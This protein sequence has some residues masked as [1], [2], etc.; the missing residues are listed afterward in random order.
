MA[1][2][3]ARP[4]AMTQPRAF[5]EQLYRTAVAAAHPASCL[6]PYL[7]ASP[8]AGRLIMLAA[9][10]AAGSMTE[11]AERHYLAAGALAPGRIHGIA[12]TRHGYGRP[13]RVVPVVEAGHPVPDAAG[14]AAGE[15]TLALADAAS[16]DDLVLRPRCG[17]AP[18]HWGA[19]APGIHPAQTQPASGGLPTP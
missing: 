1:D 2:R 10:K 14:L 13:T 8:P 11:V 12:V 18:A 9:G 3:T 6:P 5:L 16:A 7:P 19:P 17:G 15:R 4:P